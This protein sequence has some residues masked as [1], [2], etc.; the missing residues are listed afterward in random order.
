MLKRPA[1]VH[2]SAF[3]LHRSR[4]GFTLL[5]MMLALV[6]FAVGTIGVT[7]LLHRAQA[8]STDG[9]DVLISTGLAQRCLEELRNA[10]YANLETTTCAV[11]S[12]FSP[13]SLTKTVTTPSTNLKQIVVTVSWT[14]TGGQANVALQTYR[15]AN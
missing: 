8:G 14:A 11:P 15:S 12:G 4:S 6:L 13:F 5:E 9:E 3:G 2:N 7:D 10:S 1:G